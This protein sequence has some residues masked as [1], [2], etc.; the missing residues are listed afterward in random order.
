MPQRPLDNVML[1]AFAEYKADPSIGLTTLAVRFGITKQG[2]ALRFKK[3]P[4]YATIT[5]VAGGVLSAGRAGQVSRNCITTVKVPLKQRRKS[6]RKK[7][8]HR[9]KTGGY[10]GWDK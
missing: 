1:E 2:L 5:K 7:R 4:E 9:R 3:I 10:L 6:G 8:S